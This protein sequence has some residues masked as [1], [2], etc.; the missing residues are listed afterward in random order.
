M[1]IHDVYFLIAR[2]VTK[3]GYSGYATRPIFP[4]L[5]GDTL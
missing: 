2:L 3:S 1:D 5:A 4:L